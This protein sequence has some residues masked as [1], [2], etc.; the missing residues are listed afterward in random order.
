MGHALIVDDDADAA[1]MLAEL[2]V[3]HGFTAATARTMREARRQLAM[4]TPDVVF[5]TARARICSRIGK[6]WATPKSSSS[7]GMPASTR[8][9]RR[10]AWEPPITSS[11][12]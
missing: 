5:R 11:S 4:N 2:S 1:E 8:P 7:P 3:E 10:C 12:R 6:P 9:S